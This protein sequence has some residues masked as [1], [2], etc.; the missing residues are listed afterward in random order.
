MCFG[1]PVLSFVADKVGSYLGTVIGAGL[2]M[3][4][5]FTA[6]L[7]WHVP[8]SSLAL[9]FVTIGVCCAYQ[10]LAIYKVS[11]YV[12]A[13]VAG[14]TTAVANMIIMTFGYIFHAVI[15]GVVDRLGG[16]HVSK[17]LWCGVGVI[18]LA[19]CL[20]SLGFFLLALKRKEAT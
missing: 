8:T 15:G 13:E 11:T 9:I 4:I 17:A 16:V 5:G 6:L 10:I 14:L 18:P 7:G 2:L 3:A 1:S 20:G 12:R 19:L